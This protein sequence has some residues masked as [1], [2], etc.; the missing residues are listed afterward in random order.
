MKKLTSLE[1]LV[2][3]AE[4]RRI[5]IAQ[6]VLENQS[7]ELGITPQEIEQDFEEKLDVMAV[8]LTEGLQGKLRSSGGL[9]GGEAKRL[10]AAASVGKTLFG[11]PFD[12]LLARA[13]AVTEVNASMGRIVAAP[14]A[15]SCG[16]LPA[17]IFTIGEQIKADRN[18]YIDAL[19]TAAGVGMVIAYRATLSGAEGGCQAEIGSASAM[20]AAAG[21]EMA[22]GSPRQAVNAAAMALKNFLGLVCDP[23]AGLVEVPCVKRNAGGAAMAAMAIELSLAG[24]TSTIPVDEVIDAMQEIGKVIPC[25]LRETAQGGLAITPTARR[26]EKEMN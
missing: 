2:L 7:E 11:Q 19:L 1:H 8:S 20:A 14:T 23:V 10:Q 12:V 25:S 15:G 24:I 13:M 22:G 3:E 9:V 5:K 18:A 26:I 6:A 4:R 21:V 16:V 17:V